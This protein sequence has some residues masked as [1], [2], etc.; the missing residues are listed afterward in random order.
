SAMVV[1]VA[2]CYL[3]II[4]S[5]AYLAYR[6]TGRSWVALMA[7]GFFVISAW[8]V[9]YF[10]MISYTP[11]ATLFTWLTWCLVVWQPGN[12]TGQLLVISLAGLTAAGCLGCSAAGGVALLGICVLVLANRG[13]RFNR[14]QLA[15]AALFFVSLLA[16]LGILWWRC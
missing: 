7:V 5:V 3:V 14:S 10:F 15:V 12:R 4:G 6:V 2:L 16:G 13:P 8:P 9:T 1:Y 11:T